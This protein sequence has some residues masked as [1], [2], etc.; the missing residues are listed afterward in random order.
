M[1]GGTQVQGVLQEKEMGVAEEWG[2]ERQR[3][4]EG[5]GW[6]G[7]MGRVRESPEQRKAEGQTVGSREVGR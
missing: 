1:E 6:G 7:E 2:R 4:R 5:R 3:E